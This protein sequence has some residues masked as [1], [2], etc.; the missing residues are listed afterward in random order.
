MCFSVT[1]WDRLYPMIFGIPFN[2]AWL[3]CWIVLTVLCMW[4]AYR[5]ESKRDR[6]GRG[7]R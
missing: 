1:L 4:V 3:V 5:L 2:L 6:E 7:T